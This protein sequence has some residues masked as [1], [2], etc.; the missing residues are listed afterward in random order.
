MIAWCLMWCLFCKIN[1]KI[2]TFSC[3]YIARNGPIR[4]LQRRK[5]IFRSKQVKCF[6]TFNLVDV[7][8]YPMHFDATHQCDQ[9]LQFS[10]LWWN[11]KR[12]STLLDGFILYFAT[13]W[14]CFSKTFMKCFEQ[15]VIALNGQILKKSSCLVTLPPRIFRSGFDSQ[16]LNFKLVH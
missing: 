5:R 8:F 9:I 14:T 7:R 4:V 16:N 13:S 2:L 11:F 1:V 12:L 15:I 3:I 6:R 10:P